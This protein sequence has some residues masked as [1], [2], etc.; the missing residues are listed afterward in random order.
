MLPIGM[1]ALAA[2][3]VT[4]ENWRPAL[5]MAAAALAIMSMIG[6][7]YF[8]PLS[9]S[10]GHLTLGEAG[11]SVYTVNVDQASPH[12][13]LQSIGSATGSFLHP[14]QRI[15]ADPPAYAF[16][17]PIRVTEPL[18]F[19][20]SYWLAGVHPHLDVRR[21]IAAI[22]LSVHTFVK[23]F[24]EL[25]VVLGLILVFLI[26]SKGKQQLLHGLTRAWPVWLVGLAG[27][28][29]YAVVVVEPRYVTAFLTL[30]CIG[31]LVGL[32]VPARFS[33]GITLVVVI[34]TTFVLLA[35]VAVRVYAAKAPSK[36]ESL[37]AA[38]VLEG[39]GIKA[40]DTVARISAGNADL[41]VER[42]L[43][44]EIVAEVDHNRSAD[45]WRS[46]VATQ[47]SLLQQFASHGAKAV[48]ASS[49]EL[50]AENQ[51]QWIHLGS[52]HYWVWRPRA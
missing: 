21:E 28:L 12:W 15:F 44:V 31:I 29:M 7:V 39:L 43:R 47:V 36:N 11:R 14:P 25:F 1:L 42:V 33:R 22:K 17:F 4:A 52:T 32:P 34:A 23:L 19:D 40:G 10:R 13:Y 9:L 8:V 46:P 48:I 18:R 16:P 49:P 35:P 26:L 6:C 38:E 41:T 5:K 30:V 45:F 24:R 50:N 2:T 27:C 37:E 20:Q 3:V 51:S